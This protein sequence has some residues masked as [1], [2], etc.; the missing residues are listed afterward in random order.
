MVD[1]SL[2]S[3]FLIGLLGGLHC[4]GMCGGIVGAMSMAPRRIGK[5]VRIP[6]RDAGGGAATLMQAN[7]ALALRSGLT[8][9]L[10]Y[11]L[12]RITSYVAA[13][14]AAGALGSTAFIAQRLLPVEQVAFVITNAMLI[15]LGLYLVGIVRSFG[16]LEAIGKHPWRR[17][18]PLAG[19]LLHADGFGGA[20]AAGI[21]WGWVP[22]GMVYG[23]LIAAMASGSALDGALLAAAFGLGTLPSLVALGLSLRSLRGALQNRWLR[24]VAGALVITFGIA[25]LARIDPFEHLHQ[26]I[27]ACLSIVR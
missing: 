7:G 1:V 3:V 2:L 5:P 27:D 19:R 9:V 23:V 24:I 15:V 4:A 21:V 16:P 18:Q 8:L 11:N 14:A 22:C 12:G 13:G 25:G 6:V 20:V 17:L 26:A 10:G